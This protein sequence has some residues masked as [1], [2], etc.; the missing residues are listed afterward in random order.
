MQALSVKGHNGTVTFDG[1]TVT[2]TRTGFLARAT[3][4]KGE[5]RIPLRHITAVQFK[6]AG[7][8][9]NGYIQ[10]TLAGGVE[11]R[12]TFGR[13]TTDAATDE[14]SV[15]FTKAQLAE[16]EGLRTTIE[17]ALAAPVGAQPATADPVSQLQQLAQLHQAGALTD[18]EFAQAKASLL[19]QMR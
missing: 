19:G 9:V 2:I 16:F 4:G 1:S 14:N 18:A 11:R 8:A 12:S 3:V 10:F 7:W 5:K 6:A 15:V 17:D 13:Q